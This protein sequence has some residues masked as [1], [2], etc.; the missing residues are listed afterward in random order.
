MTTKS[1]ML[2]AVT[3]LVLTLA[4]SLIVW[5]KKPLIFSPPSPQTWEITLI[6]NTQNQT[7]SLKK[8]AVL[9]QLI[10]QDFRGAQDSPYT[11]LVL[12]N[13]DKLLYQNKIHI[14]EQLIFNMLQNWPTA[15]G[16]SQIQPQ[17]PTELTSTVF[18]PYFKEGAKIQIS[19]SS[20]K[21]L[22]FE[23][24]LK[25]AGF[26]FPNL[27]LAQTGQAGGGPLQV[28]IL[29]DNYPNNSQYQ[30]DAQSI[31]TTF[32]QTMP[33]SLANPG[34]F[35]FN[36][37]NNSESFQCASSGIVPGPR[38][39]SGCILNESGIRSVASKYVPN[40]SKIIVLVYNPNAAMIDG[41][42]LGVTNDV[43]GD[44]VILATHR[45]EPPGIRAPSFTQ[46]A[47]HEFLGHA[48]GQLYDRYVLTTKPGIKYGIR[49]NCSDNPAGE[50]FWRSAGVAGSYSGCDSP[51]LYAATPTECPP[52]PARPGFPSGPMVN[53]GSRTSLMSAADCGGSQF[54]TV[55]QA[56]IRTQIIPRYQTVSV[57]T[58]TPT[59]VTPQVT[60]IPQAANDCSFVVNNQPAINNQIVRGEVPTQLSARRAQ[61]SYYLSL[62][63]LNSRV[64]NIV[65]AVTQ[66]DSLTTSWNSSALFPNG[67]VA[68]KCLIT[69]TVLGGNTI[70][71]KDVTVNVQ[72]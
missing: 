67:Q 4:L 23:T 34:I 49:S 25:P 60:P 32:N 17:I 46:V 72:N 30:S 16:S 55:E 20:V 36:V 48:V 18:I 26:N 22:E 15:T 61:P 52:P 13:Q 19:R 43:G 10:Q 5:L 9:N 50:A 8:I 37:V 54:D 14:S 24:T 1:A 44:I 7:L 2:L 63:L 65:G 71:S 21:V 70:F 39:G 59:P 66:A 56:W 45:I 64:G 42:M 51:A 68:L 69:D 28:V 27:V 3:V 35:N 47:T 41:P 29:K 57:P 6:F 53:G 12:T 11:L 33:Y 58:P 31:I 62:I 40:F 38:F